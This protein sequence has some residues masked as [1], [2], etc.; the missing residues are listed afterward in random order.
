MGGLAVSSYA[1]M[2]YLGVTVGMCAQAYAAGV[3][4]LSTVRVWV[5]TLLL[6][7]CALGGARLLFVTSHW[8]IYRRAPS[9]IWRRSEGGMSLYGGMSLMLVC[10]LPVLEWVGVSFWRFWDVS[11]FCILVAMAFTRV[12]CLMHGC[13]AGRESSGRLT[14]TLSN[15]EGV[16]LRRIPVQL[17]EAAWAVLLLAGVVVLWR[18]LSPGDA[19]LI[20]AGGYG[21]GRF[22]LQPC[23]AAREWIAGVDLQQAISCVTVASSLTLLIVRHI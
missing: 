16:K 10:S 20:A 11:T 2:L 13:C 18:R 21:L 3:A 19:F 12:G 7:P 23:R 6:L 4:G 14:V 22:A 9:R 15:H 5:A 1:L 17:L 8:P